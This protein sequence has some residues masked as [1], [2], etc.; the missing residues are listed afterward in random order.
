VKNAVHHVSANLQ[1]RR[2]PNMRLKQ[3]NILLAA[4]IAILGGLTIGY[5]GMGH[6]PLGEVFKW[7]TWKHL[8]DLV[9]G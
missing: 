3:I 8:V 9:F 5:V 2:D 7:Q 6:Q 1:R 4:I